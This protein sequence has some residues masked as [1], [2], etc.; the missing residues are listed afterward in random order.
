MFKILPLLCIAVL[1]APTANAGFKSK[2]IETAFK[3]GEH[4]IPT[5]HLDVSDGLRLSPKQEMRIIF[6][7]VHLDPRVQ[8]SG[9]ISRVVRDAF[10][11]NS[12][13]NANLRVDFFRSKKV[14]LLEVEL[15]NI[16]TSSAILKNFLKD[17]SKVQRTRSGKVYVQHIVGENGISADLA[18]RFSDYY[19]FLI[20]QDYLDAKKAMTRSYRSGSAG[21]R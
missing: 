11:N 12:K 5:Q 3:K 8:D 15:E 13:I 2:L 10:D 1:V 20:K 21:V 16:D 6:H 14:T 7:K 17:A 18:D 4:P 9:T 19:E